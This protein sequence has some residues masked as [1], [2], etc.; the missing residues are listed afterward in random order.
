MSVPFC[1]EGKSRKVPGRKSRV[2]RKANWKVFC[3]VLHF[4]RWGMLKDH[5]FLTF[6]FRHAAVSILAPLQYLEIV[7]ATIFGLLIFNDFP[8]KITL[9]GIAIIICS[10]L[11]VLMRERR[12]EL[13][14]QAK[15][16]LV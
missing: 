9:L 7:A 8:N 15:Q 16:T 5:M 14:R 11:Y 12:L 1:I 13:D 2:S 3:R 10:G 4:P 6:A